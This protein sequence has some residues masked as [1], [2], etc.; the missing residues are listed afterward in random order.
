MTLPDTPPRAA[1]H[2]ADGVSLPDLV[3]YLREGVYL[4]DAN[5]VLLDANPVALD[6][7]GGAHVGG[8]PVRD[9]SR[10]NA[11]WRA[12]LDALAA[13]GA[14]REFTRQFAHPDGTTRTVLDT[15]YARRDDGV[16]TWHGV[17]VDI[18][19]HPPRG[20]V[21]LDETHTRDIATGAYAPEYLDALDAERAARPDAPIGLCV[22]QVDPGA[23]AGEPAI[24]QALDARLERMV[25]FLLRHVRGSEPVVRLAHDRLAVCL[26]GAD[27]R[28]TETVGRRIQLAAL[29]SA[30]SPFR[31][32]WA[33]RHAGESLVTTAERALRE[34]VPVRVVERSFDPPRHG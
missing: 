2:F 8:A 12:E 31:L 10:D 33:T 17:L 18:T 27:E 25:R 9:L 16:V 13:D 26:P 14:V 5:G 7:F 3:R 15:C 28:G 30:P 32:G 23:G 21:A 20:R 24:A 34:A 22:V 6:L 1:R 11:T 19:V 29:R 4:M